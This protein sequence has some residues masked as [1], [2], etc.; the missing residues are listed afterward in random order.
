LASGIIHQEGKVAVIRVRYVTRDW[1]ESQGHFAAHVRAELTLSGHETAIWGDPA[2]VSLDVAVVD[3][4]TGDDVTF[5]ADPE[6][7]ARL[8][9]FAY[10][11]GDISV[12]IDSPA[13]VE[14]RPLTHGGSVESREPIG[15]H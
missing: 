13:V 1:D 15:A 14:S 10:R 7:W 12:E 4:E 6:R 2:W 11:S 5:E 9:P 3:P 8:L